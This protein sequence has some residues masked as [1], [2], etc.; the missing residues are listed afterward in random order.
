MPFVHLKT[1]R[2]EY[3]FEI[4][5]KYNLIKGD[6]G[7]GKTTLHEL[8]SAY[9][10]TPNAV[11]CLGYN[12]LYAWPV[13]ASHLELLDHNDDI[14]IIDED[15]LILH[16]HDIASLL[17]N[18]NNY[19]LII[20]RD[21]K[22][23][24]LPISLDSIFTMKSS[25]KFHTLELLYPNASRHLYSG[26][27]TNIIVED[28]TSGLRFIKEVFSKS[29]VIIN[30]PGELELPKSSKGGKSKIIVACTEL[31][32]SGVTKM[33]II[34]DKIGIG[35]TFDDIYNILMLRDDIDIFLIDWT[36]FEDYIIT[37]P[38][39]N[40]KSVTSVDTCYID[41]LEVA[42]LDSMRQY[43]PRYSKT[44]TFKCIKRDVCKTC[45]TPCAHIY[46]NYNKLLCDR[47]EE[48]F[49]SVIHNTTTM[50]IF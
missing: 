4:K 21:T 22:F 16:R 11:N 13:N 41:N 34:L 3:Q 14:I 50:S 47:V 19:F 40:G 27:V 43:F 42:S 31:I 8:I 20:N 35:N 10:S 36:C 28:S 9:N 46:Y 44:T 37:S 7:T 33:A 2:L 12:K 30:H 26:N 49:N 18:S 15:A 32:K 5:H 23:S 17:S 25:G 39:I 45:S 38:F 29:G 1:K 6:S 24:Y 48:L